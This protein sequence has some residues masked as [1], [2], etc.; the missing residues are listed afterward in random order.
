MFAVV[1]GQ[2]AANPQE[3][4]RNAIYA[5]EYAGLFSCVHDRVLAGPNGEVAVWWGADHQL[6]GSRILAPGEVIIGRMHDRSRSAEDRLYLYGGGG[7]VFFP[8][9]WSG[10]DGTLFV[11]KRG[12]EAGI[13]SLDADGGPVR[14]VLKLDPA[15]KGVTLNAVGH[16]GEAGTEPV[17]INAA[18]TRSLTLFPDTR[19]YAAGI[20]YLG[21]P[22]KSRL[23]YLPYQLPL[24][25][26]ATGQVA[27]KFGPTGILL[28]GR[29][30][31]ARSL[32]RFRRAR[33]ESRVV[34]DASLSG[35]TLLALT[36]SGRGN[37][38]IV[39]ISPAGISEKPICTDVFVTDFR[40]RTTPNPLVSPDTGYRPLV[41]A[42]ALDPSGREAMKP[43]RPIVTLHRLDDGPPRDAILFFGGGPGASQADRDHSLLQID[44]LLKPGR[45]IVS[46][47][48]SG[49]VGGGSELTRRLG[50]HGIAALEQD[51]DS[52][53][54][55]L[56]RRRYRR[57]FIV[58]VSFGGV[59]ALVALDRH[60]DRFPA[61]FFFA[62]LL[63]L[64]DPEEHVNR[65]K[66]DS[67]FA[68]TQLNYERALFGGT[69]GRERF[70]AEL[71]ALVR[72]ADLRPSDHFYF[73]QLDPVSR[74]ADLPSG[75]AAM[76]DVI[77]A[78]N[79]AAILASPEALRAIEE[80]IR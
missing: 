29:N 10:H 37:R 21:A 11:R 60:R 5:M 27:G 77:P 33:G 14:E 70:R 34:L 47:E 69:A 2:A 67:V 50:E 36:L 68:D 66:F 80:Q 75:T 4:G 54:R 46:V 1:F 62:P 24:V 22:S 6:L 65:G 42:F 78:T 51:V 48:Y 7:N 56:D 40:R 26:Q 12:P 38:A 76:H 49:G 57:V 59:P 41:R 32:A 17:G 55:W 58:A 43:G 45:D 15:W 19:S 74:P 16:G 13:L 64:P 53:V 31:L 63:K 8:L 39:R 9:R 44:R 20:A 18:Y 35:E 28:E 73:A 71:P 25:D 52:V 3:S 61:A 30:R 23:A 79:H 72:R